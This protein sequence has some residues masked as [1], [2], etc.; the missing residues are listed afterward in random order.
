[1][2]EEPVDL[3]VMLYG[4][5]KTS[6]VFGASWLQNQWP[7]VEEQ[8]RWYRPWITQ[9]EKDLKLLESLLP[10]SEII[11]TYRSGLRDISQFLQTAYEI[12][13]AAL[14]ASIAS[15]IEL[16]VPKGDESNKNFDIRA[17]I[18]GVAIQADA[19]TRDDTSISER[20]RVQGPYGIAYY[21]RDRPTLDPHDAAA[22]GIPVQPPT[23]GR[24][25]QTLPEST[26]IKNVLLDAL[27][28]LPDNG[29]NVVLFGHRFGDRDDLDRALY[30][31]EVC[32]LIR[33]H[34]TKEVTSEWGRFPNGA[35]HEGDAGMPF[36]SLSAVIWMRLMA[37]DGHLY[38]GYRLYSNNTAQSPL[39]Q[40]AAEALQRQI[41]AWMVLPPGSDM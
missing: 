13:G 21:S 4:Y 29:L 14:L 3:T 19:K 1:M 38:R 9:A 34:S 2:T 25:A 41:D 23:P 15:E 5:P 12:H 20:F 11:P 7:T 10:P 22:H 40:R 35:F 37:Y 26:T 36:R 31:P 30:G 27:S 28:Q 16:H 8:L 39:P 6:E 24:P 17:Q 33:N 18:H 32:H